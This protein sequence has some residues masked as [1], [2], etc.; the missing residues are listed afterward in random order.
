M[1]LL[2]RKRGIRSGFS[3]STFKARM[4]DWSVDTWGIESSAAWV[5]QHL[6]LAR[7]AFENAGPYFQNPDLPRARRLGRRGHR[8]RSRVRGSVS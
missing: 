2:K 1:A 8:S 7:E 3:D 4:L 6:A 5:R